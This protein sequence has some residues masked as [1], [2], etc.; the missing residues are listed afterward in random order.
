MLLE[1]YQDLI[2]KFKKP[3]KELLEG[4]QQKEKSI[5]NPAKVTV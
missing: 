2:E 4:D 3:N 5:Q 1:K